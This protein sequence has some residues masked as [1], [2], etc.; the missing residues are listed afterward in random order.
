MAGSNS[1]FLFGKMS[2]NVLIHKLGVL[3]HLRP[4][5]SLHVAIEVSEGGC[6]GGWPWQP[7]A[8]L[9]QVLG[10]PI[11]GEGRRIA[12][13]AQEITSTGL[14]VVLSC[15]WEGEDGHDNLGRNVLELGVPLLQC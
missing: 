8:P 4:G 15:E 3:G 2:H 9:V 12:M 7:G 13:A 11:L 10:S 14:L 1:V 5:S 6:R